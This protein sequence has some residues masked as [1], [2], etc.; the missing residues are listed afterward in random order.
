[1][2]SLA[3]TFDIA[4]SP[5]VTA[6]AYAAGEVMGGLMEFEVAAEN[7]KSVLITG[8]QVIFKAAVQP[9]LRAVFFNAAPT[10]ML[11]N[12]AYALAAGDAFKARRTLTSTLHG[13]GYVSHGTPKSISLTPPSPFVMAPYAGLKTIGLCLVDDT[14]VTLTS[15]GDLQV[16]ISGLG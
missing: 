6:G 1:M 10:A 3:H 11:D 14:G 4:K 7:G 16:R 8:V 13:E 9:A 5:L 15:T 2:K 12:A